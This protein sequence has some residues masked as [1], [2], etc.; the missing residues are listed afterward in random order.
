MK[1]LICDDHRLLSDCIAAFFQERGDDVRQAASPEEA[2]ELLGREAADVLVLDLGFPQ[3]GGDPVP[4]LRSL[5]P[6]TPIVVF[7]GNSDLP[8][9]ERARVSGARGFVSK[10]D[11]LDR[12]VEVVD[13]VVEHGHDD[14]ANWKV[15]HTPAA[16]GHDQP[17]YF[18][19]ARE[20]QALQGLAEGKNTTELALWMGVRESTVSTHVQAV[21]SK[22]GV[23][24]RLEA[25]AVAT[26]N[27]LVTV[28]AG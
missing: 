9:V 20:V 13:R 28:P 7:S 4:P 11:S 23:H 1:V 18:L 2:A 14:E 6:A 19:T 26:A 25:V 27:R 3:G 22:L 10:G 24:S 21:L 17:P 8:M 16:H 12:L 5:A 15:E